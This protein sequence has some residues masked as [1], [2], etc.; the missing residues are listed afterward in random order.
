MIFRSNLLFHTFVCG[1][2]ATIMYY[3]DRTTSTLLKSIVYYCL[4]VL[5][6]KLLFRNS[7][8][9]EIKS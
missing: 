2:C 1:V 7:N 5:V 8:P 9:P 6:A 3:N 4:G